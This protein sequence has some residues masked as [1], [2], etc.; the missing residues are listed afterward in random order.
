MA[1]RLFKLNFATAHFGTGGLETSE[2]LLRADTLFSA[3]CQE[4]LHVSSAHFE[5]IVSA[6]RIGTLLLSDGLPYVEDIYLLPKPVVRIAAGESDSSLKKQFK[7]VS[8]IP[9]SLIDS[10]VAGS[11]DVSELNSIQSRI[12]VSSIYGKVFS[13]NGKK[14]AEPYRVGVFSFTESAGLWVL[15]T[16]TA[17]ELTLVSDLLA[18]LAESGVGGERSAGMGRFTLTQTDVLPPLLAERT[19]PTD[20]SPRKMTL[21][22]ALPRDDELE[23]ALEGAT[24]VPVR[25]SGF[26]ASNT[27]ADTP[28]RKRD[29]YK[30]A[31]GSVFRSPFTGDVFD[32]QQDS[33]HPVWSYAKPIWF[34]L[35][36][37]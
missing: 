31:A 12:G 9:L 32:V 5:Q 26:V 30:F 24:A 7:K 3:L 1:P 15:A 14:D 19:A 36:G 33:A 35:K 23:S 17:D 21:T 4:A 28:L 8:Y 2:P 11:S 29:L 10:F 6:A 20:K 18:G 37:A 27:Y 13:R 22:T 16:G 25:R 34:G